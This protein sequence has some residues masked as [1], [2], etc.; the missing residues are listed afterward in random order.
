MHPS[1]HQRFWQITALAALLLCG[2]SVFSRGGPVANADNGGA[3]MD[4]MIAMVG[5]SNTHEHLYLI[6]TRTKN[7]LMYESRSGNNFT[8]VAGRSYDPDMLCLT[9]TANKELPFD[10]KGYTTAKIQAAVQQIQ[11]AHNLKRP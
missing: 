4:G 10:S 3:S 1:G 6:D 2:Y 8:L 11:A 5:N 7:I 9:R